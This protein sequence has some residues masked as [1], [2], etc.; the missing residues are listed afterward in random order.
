MHLIQHIKQKPIARRKL[1]TAL[2]ATILIAGS[3]TWKAEAA[4]VTGVGGL[5]ALSKTHSPVEHVGYY[6][7]HSYGG[8]GNYE[9]GYWPYGYENGWQD[10]GFFGGTAPEEDPE[11]TNETPLGA[12]TLQNP[13][14]E[15]HP[16]GGL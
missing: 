10:P 13:I 6:R 9:Y 4:A 3:T 2:T 11:V 14:G 16:M 1:I 15:P 5:P 7:P 8:Y 12:W